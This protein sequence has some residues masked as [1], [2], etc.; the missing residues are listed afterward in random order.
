MTGSSDELTNCRNYDLIAQQFDTTRGAKL[1][2]HAYFKQL[3][4]NLR[5]S[6]DILD[7]G[8]GTGHRALPDLIRRGFN[9]L[10]IDGSKAMLDIFRTRYP[11]I[12][13]IES[14]MTR[15]IPERTFDAVIAWDSFFHLSQDAQRH[16]L[17]S[18][19]AWIKP[20]G[21]LLF[22]SG[23]INGTFRGY[24]FGHDFTYSSFT[25]VEYETML[26]KNGFSVLLSEFDEPDGHLH[27]V[28]LAKREA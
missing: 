3:A 28:W 16:M 27:R 2:E 20:G 18:F 12:T 21:F 15:F 13:T 24:M 6:A 11:S 23:P 26:Q 9:I 25:Q 1:W 19:A 10:A 22:T 4:E 5:S 7:C 14:D 17:H 8:C